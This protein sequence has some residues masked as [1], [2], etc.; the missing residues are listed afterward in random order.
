MS[1][2]DDEEFVALILLEYWLD[3]WVV[4]SRKAQCR[5][6]R[7]LSNLT[8]LMEA[9][10]QRNKMKN[11]DDKMNRRWYGFEAFITNCCCVI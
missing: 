5:N 9:K 4:G 6:L 7:K 11:K 1:S 2:D 8:S 10:K 3:R